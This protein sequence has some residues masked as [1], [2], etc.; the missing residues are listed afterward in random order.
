MKGNE[1]LEEILAE[2]E[3]EEIDRATMR[4]VSTVADVLGMN[5]YV[6]EPFREAIG[7]VLASEL[8]LARMK[9]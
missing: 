9:S 2:S 5:N 6:N 7:I 8:W 4:R 1:R 3:M